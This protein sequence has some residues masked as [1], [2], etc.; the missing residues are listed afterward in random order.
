MVN[1]YVYHYSPV[2]SSNCPV[3]NDLLSKSSWSRKIKLIS[4]LIRTLPCLTEHLV[5]LLTGSGQVDGSEI[6]S[7]CKPDYA[8][9]TCTCWIW[10]CNEFKP[11]WIPM[12]VGHSYGPIVAPYFSPQEKP[13]PS[14][15]AYL[16]ARIDLECFPNKFWVQLGL[17]PERNI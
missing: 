14:P 6:L 12:H 9:R 7:D 13:H 17:S 5:W 16:N 15:T 8:V 11:Y 10:I 4:E 3:W 1:F 2:F